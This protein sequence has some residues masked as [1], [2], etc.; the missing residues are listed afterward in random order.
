MKSEI[1][2]QKS[3]SLIGCGVLLGI[4]ILSGI[5]ARFVELNTLTKIGV[6]VAA[7]LSII[8]LVFWFKNFKKPA[9][10]FVLINHDGIWEKTYNQV[11]AWDT[12]IEAYEFNVDHNGSSSTEH[13]IMIKTT[14]EFKIGNERLNNFIEGLLSATNGGEKFRLDVDHLENVDASALTQLINQATQATNE[15]ERE[16]IFVAYLKENK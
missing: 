6:F 3:K 12:I 5:V 2:I 10:V 8:G 16:A 9:D 15:D 11:V 13:F 7:L 14:D 1:K 4:L